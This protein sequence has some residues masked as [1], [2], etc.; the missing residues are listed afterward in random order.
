[1]GLRDAGET[2][3]KTFLGPIGLNSGIKDLLVLVLFRF[4]PNLNFKLVF[5]RIS[6]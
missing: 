6:L 2:C 1:M 3:F 4:A 5:Y